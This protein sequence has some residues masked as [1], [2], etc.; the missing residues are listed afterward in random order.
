MS[1]YNMVYQKIQERGML[2]Y[3]I[4]DLSNICYTS[5]FTGSTGFVVVDENGFNFVTDSRYARQTEDE[6][7][8]H[9]EKTIVKSY[10]SFLYELSHKYS[11]IY[12][13]PLTKLDIYMSLS[14]KTKVVVDVEGLIPKSRM[15]KNSA[16]IMEIKKSYQIAAEGF[17]KFITEISYRESENTW[18]AVLEYNM[19]KNGSRTPSFDTIIA[20]GPRGALPHG[21]ASDKIIL[22]EEP[23]V[24]DYG[25]KTTYCSDITR[26]I[27]SGNDNFI[28]KIMNIVNDAKKKAIESAKP[29]IRAS[30]LDKIARSYLEKA[31]YGKFFNHG[32]GHGV[33][34][35]V[36]EKPSLNPQDD[37]ILQPG[38]VLTV[39]PGLY[40]DD[41]FGVRVEDTILINENGCEILSSVLDRHFYKI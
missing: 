11:K 10:V 36:H 24:V 12:I 39:E 13:D 14:K 3:L 6:I 32:L 22:P 20:S 18:A 5:D 1:N 27:Y 41:N 30:E 7:P 8:G 23:V 37:T 19:K 4:S 31:G 17:L 40:F 33:G 21:V 34:I 38:M 35:D 29:G 15:I 16:E 9:F 2:P 28:L 26:M 25:A